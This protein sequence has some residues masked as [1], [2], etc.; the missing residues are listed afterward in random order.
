MLDPA[1][2]ADRLHQGPV[3]DLT[4][5]RLQLELVRTDDAALAAALQEIA[6]SVSAACDSLRE[7]VRE[8]GPPQN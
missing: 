6:A 7:I 3:Q 4:A 1:D 2:L 5:A 8:I